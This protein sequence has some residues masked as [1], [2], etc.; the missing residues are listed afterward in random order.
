M[1]STDLTLHYPFALNKSLTPPVGYGPTLAFTRATAATFVGVDGLIQTSATG[2]ARFDHNPATAPYTSLGLLV[3]EARTNLCLQSQD[4]DT[5][6]SQNDLTAVVNQAV[7]PDGTTTADEM[8]DDASG[9]FDTCSQ[10]ITVGQS[11]DNYCASVYV[12]K[13]VSSTANFGLELKFTGGVTATSRVDLDASDGTT[14]EDSSPVDSGVVDAGD[15]WRLWI[16]QDNNNDASNL[17]MTITMYPAVG[18][19]LGTAA[20]AGVGTAHVWGMQIEVGAFPTSYLPTT[21]STVTRNKEEYT[22]ADVSW[23]DT[24]ATIVGT[25]Y[26]RGSF[27]HDQDAAVHLWQLDDG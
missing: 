18:T 13:T 24:A 4:L 9:G 27:P 7:A 25:F 15:Y 17:T 1:P 6:W 8:E 12:K 21:T 14:G 10:A 16:V 2:V 23:L 5:T 11:S 20:A 19:V 3:E 22:T 26:V